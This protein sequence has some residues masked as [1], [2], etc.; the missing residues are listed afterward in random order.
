M[1]TPLISHHKRAL[2]Q[3]V[4]QKVWN[5]HGNAKVGVRGVLET[6]T[7][8]DFRLELLYHLSTDKTWTH[9]RGRGWPRAEKVQQAD[10]SCRLWGLAGQ[11]RQCKRLAP[12]FCQHSILSRRSM[13]TRVCSKAGNRTLS[14]LKSFQ[15]GGLFKIVF[16]LLHQLT[17]QLKF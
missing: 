6:G 3:S 8:C 1:T 16:Q 14:W 2:Q 15:S 4:L 7:L 5:T 10:T 13:G 11:E 9:H 12:L 17:N